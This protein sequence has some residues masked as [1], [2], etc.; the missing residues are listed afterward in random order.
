MRIVIAVAAFQ[1][2][3]FASVLGAANGL[4]WLGPAVVLVL[5]AAFVAKQPNKLRAAAY[6]AVCAALGFV[7]DSALTLAGVLAFPMDSSPARSPLWMVGLW[8]NFAWFAPVGLRWLYDRPALA[9][10]L[11]AAGGPAAYWAGQRLGAL[12]WSAPQA[13]GAIAAEWAAATPAIFWLASRL[14]RGGVAA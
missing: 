13:L 5:A 7:L 12:E 10:C 8:A 4:D 3:W 9:A 11:G 2:G 6:L 14:D 1:A